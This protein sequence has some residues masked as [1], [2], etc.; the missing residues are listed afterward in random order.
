MADND[1]KIKVILDKATLEQLKADNRKMLMQVQADAKKSIEQLKA[2]NKLM[3]TEATNLSK[4]RIARTKAETAAKNLEWKKQVQAEKQAIKEAEQER[5][6][7]DRQAIEDAKLLSRVRA[8]EMQAAFPKQKGGQ[9]LYQKLEVGE[10]IATITMGIGLAVMAAQQF[11]REL[12]A[13][14]QSGAELMVLRNYFEEISGSIEQAAQDLTLLR[15]A[16]SGNLSDKELIAYANRMREVG[17]TTNETAQ[18]L[19]IAERISD[20]AAVTFGEAQVKLFRWVE[21]GKGRGFEQMGIDI[22]S[23]TKKTEDYV[24]AQGQTIQTMDAEELSAIRLKVAVEQM[25]MSIDDINKKTP[26]L[27]DKIVSATKKIDNL[28]DS[29]GVL[30]A[31]GLEPTV[32][33][34]GSLMEVMNGTTNSMKPFDDM[35]K[36]VT[37]GVLGFKDVMNALIS[38]LSTVFDLVGNKLPKALSSFYNAMSNVYNSL[39]QSVPTTFFSGVAN[40]VSS[41]A[42]SIRDL[43]SLLDKV[44]GIDIQGQYGTSGTW[45]ATPEPKMYDYETREGVRKNWGTFYDKTY[46]T[47]SSKG[48][49]KGNTTDALKE[50]VRET[51]KLAENYVKLVNLADNYSA[52]IRSIAFPVS[53]GGSGLGRTGPADQ[54]SGAQSPIGQTMEGII[55]SVSEPF[56]EAAS[57]IS[58]I[59]SDM[60]NTLGLETDSFVGRLVS[61]FDTVLSIVNMIVNTLNAVNAV[62]GLIGG[63]MSL[64]PGGG[65][66][67]NA[68]TAMG[69]SPGGMP[70]PM[71]QSGNSRPIVNVV[72]QSEVEKIKAIKFFDNNFNAYQNYLRS[73]SY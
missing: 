33:V 70:M 24:R 55:N 4:E 12:W 68:A 9:S 38:P 21:T 50:Q 45:D 60:M 71:L 13:M 31:E 63:I 51:G 25:G 64:I 58:N 44:P 3:Q 5:K 2:D 34:V 73:N 52:I 19:D 47:S 40:L 57:S 29:T 42:G 36:S 26:E 65:L 66:I 8:R 46:S 61:G 6:R 37:Q 16:A 10:N 35:L 48:G 27:D 32:T 43:L 28:K 53:E 30:L 1:F 49:S 15:T 17:L 39:S 41:T 56:K 7:A 69:G 20:R 14:A 54:F 67:A 72:V 22:N 23:L 62:K 59:F 18:I 11:S